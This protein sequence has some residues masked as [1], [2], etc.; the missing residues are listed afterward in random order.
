M[1]YTLYVFHRG[2]W[3]PF[4]VEQVQ[5]YMS[6]VDE[7]NQA[8]VSI[9]SVAFQTS[10]KQDRLLARLGDDAKIHIPEATDQLIAFA[11]ENGIYRYNAL[12]IGLDVLGFGRDHFLPVSVLVDSENT[13]LATHQSGDYRNRPSLDYFLRYL[14]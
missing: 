1:P 4:C 12:P 6:R 9:V 7:L 11:K 3:S 14:Y 10:L 5:N 13:I 8:Q 2:N